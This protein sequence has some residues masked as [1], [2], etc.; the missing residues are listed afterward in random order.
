MFMK[1][2]TSVETFDQYKKNSRTCRSLCCH[3]FPC[4]QSERQIFRG[5][6]K[7]CQ[8]D[9]RRIRLYSQSGSKRTADEPVSCDG[10]N[11]SGCTEQSFCKPRHSQLETPTVLAPGGC[12]ASMQHYIYPMVMCPRHQHPTLPLHR[13]S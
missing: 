7:P 11:P 4:Y 2:R 12:R 1:G 13:A 6:G 10:C 3:G 9:H 5:N 8:T